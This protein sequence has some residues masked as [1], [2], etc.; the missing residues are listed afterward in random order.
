MLRTKGALKGIHA[1]LESIRPKSVVIWEIVISKSVTMSSYKH[2]VPA[3]VRMSSHKCN[4]P[5]SV[6]KEFPQV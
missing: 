6:I 2:N 1:L 5:A 4:V 3:S